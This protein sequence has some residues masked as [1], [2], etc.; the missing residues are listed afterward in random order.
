MFVLLRERNSRVTKRV[1][2]L[3]AGFISV[4]DQSRQ[5]FLLGNVS[6]RPKTDLRLQLLE[7]RFGLLVDFY[8]ALADLLAALVEYDIERFALDPDWV[9]DDPEVL[10]WNEDVFG[11]SGRSCGGCGMDTEGID[12]TNVSPSPKPSPDDVQQ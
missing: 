10:E 11:D 6:S 12:G 2:D 7:V 9:P 5:Q 1:D 3:R 4:V 8:A